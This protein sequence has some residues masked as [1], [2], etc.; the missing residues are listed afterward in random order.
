ME[1]MSTGTGTQPAVDRSL[2]ETIERFNEAFNRFDPKEV[3][4]F[5]ASDGTLLTPVGAYGEGR[6][7]VERVYGEDVQTILAGTRSR[8]TILRARQVAADCVLLDLDHDLQN[9][10][11]PDGTTGSMK[12]HVVILAR[13]SG[14]GWQMLDVRPYGFLP[15]PQLH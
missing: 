12:L 9:F 1:Q 11:R 7:G 3:A 15:R 4:S 6:A 13:R 2:Q 5:W 8:F 14:D 10:R